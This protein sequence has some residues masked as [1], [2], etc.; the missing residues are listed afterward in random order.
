[1][2]FQLKSEIDCN[3]T[4]VRDS[5]LSAVSHKH[6]PKIVLLFCLPHTVHS[7]TGNVWA[8]FIQLLEILVARC[9]LGQMH[10]SCGELLL[11]NKGKQKGNW[12]ESRLCHTSTTMT[13]SWFCTCET[14]EKWK[15]AHFHWK[16]KAFDAFFNFKDSKLQ[17]ELWIWFFALDYFLNDKT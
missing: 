15:C 7:S 11:K 14:H 4:I 1:M 12:W 2:C 8:S 16:L 9:S 5:S 3:V 17:I 13:W 6:L 10:T